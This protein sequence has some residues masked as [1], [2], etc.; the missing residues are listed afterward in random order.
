MKPS[1]SSIERAI[2]VYDPQSVAQVNISSLI[3]NF[4]S[5]GLR[6]LSWMT[7]QKFSEYYGVPNSTVKKWAVWHQPIFNQVTIRMI[8]D[9]LIFHLH[10]YCPI[11][12]RVETILILAKWKRNDWKTRGGNRVSLSI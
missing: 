6:A 12:K 4:S 8:D 10:A 3:Q 1:V 5:E 9:W 11:P 2:I 7:Q